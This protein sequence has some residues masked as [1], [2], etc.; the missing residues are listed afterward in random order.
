MS[1][2]IA[3]RSALAA[4][5]AEVARLWQ[6]CGLVTSYNDPGQDF[7]FALGKLNSDVLVGVDA[8][9]RIVGSIMVGHDGH[10]GWIYYVAADQDY[11]EQGIGR[12]MTAAAE[13]WLQKRQVVK[14]MLLVRET[15]TEVVNFY[16][17]IG[18]EPVPRV[19]MQK[20]LKQDS[21]LSDDWPPA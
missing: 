8:T 14:V 21:H 10:R 2:N 7:R 5:E 18:F 3:V 16:K 12:L 9:D 1:L 6:T 4:D 20:W 13:E 17:H 11:R 15:N 19:V